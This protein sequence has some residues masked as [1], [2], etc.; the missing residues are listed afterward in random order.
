MDRGAWWDT[1][2]EVANSQ[3][4][5]NTHA[6]KFKISYKNKHSP[7]YTCRFGAQLSPNLQQN[8]T[9]K[10]TVTPYTLMKPPLAYKYR[11]QRFQKSK[12]IYQD[13]R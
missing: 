12:T 10:S 8:T 13:S 5:L 6:T 2:Q 1:V 3:T 9:H 11:L 7:I 4:P